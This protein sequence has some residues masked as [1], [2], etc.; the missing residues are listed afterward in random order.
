M[1]KHPLINYMTLGGHDK[2]CHAT[3]GKEESSLFMQN[4]HFGQNEA[5][6][7][8]EE[9]ERKKNKLVKVKITILK[10]KS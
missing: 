3:G 2:E 10:A 4:I 6:Q 1:Y 5:R 9:R 8:S 7:P